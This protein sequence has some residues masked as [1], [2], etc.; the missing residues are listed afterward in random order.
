MERVSSTVLGCVRHRGP[1]LD[2]KHH[3]SVQEGSTVPL[4]PPQTE[5]SWGHSLSHMQLLQRH[6]RERS[7]QLLYGTVQYLDPLLP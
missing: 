5:K 3:I 2:Q 6:H 7:D 1:L 4:L